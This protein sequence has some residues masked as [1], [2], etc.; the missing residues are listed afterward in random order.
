MRVVWRLSGPG[1][2]FRRCLGGEEDY[3]DGVFFEACPSGFFL[4]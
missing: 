4:W 2:M 1:R 3:W